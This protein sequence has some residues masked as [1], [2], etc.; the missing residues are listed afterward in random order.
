[1]ECNLHGLF[2]LSFYL[3]KR[4]VQRLHDLH[5]SFSASKM[6]LKVQM[7]IFAAII[8]QLPTIVTIEDCSVV[9]IKITSELSA[10][11]AIVV[12]LICRPLQSLNPVPNL[13]SQDAS[14]ILPTVSFLALFILFGCEG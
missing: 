5:L 4:P 12:R 14:A 2:P 1:M 9:A 10:A 3:I 11:Q 8:R 7:K 6:L 13:I